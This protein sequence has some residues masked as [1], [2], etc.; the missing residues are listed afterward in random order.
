MEPAYLHNILSLLPSMN[1]LFSQ[2]GSTHFSICS[3]VHGIASIWN[4]A[5]L[6]WPIQNPL[7]LSKSNAYGIF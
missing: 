1:L 4:A 3:A 2:N 6:F 5:F 7:H